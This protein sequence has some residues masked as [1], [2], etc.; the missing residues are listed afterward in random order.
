MM[1]GGLI[2][3]SV[4]AV[5]HAPVDYAFAAVSTVILGFALIPLGGTIEW[6]FPI[7]PRNW[8]VRMDLA[9]SAMSIAVMVCAFWTY[10]IVASLVG[11]V[12]RALAL[13]IG[14]PLA[15]LSALPYFIV[16][17]IGRRRYRRNPSL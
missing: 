11:S 13:N 6:F 7:E 5:S 15:F 1:F 9:V 17:L 14:L 8:R 12:S 4:L 16:N 10:S 3:L 2:S